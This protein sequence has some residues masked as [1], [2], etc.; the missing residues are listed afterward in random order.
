M[1]GLLGWEKGRTPKIW[2]L[3]GE[4]GTRPERDQKQA[5]SGANSV[6]LPG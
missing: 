1:C 2:I 5:M 4:A 3:G 6:K